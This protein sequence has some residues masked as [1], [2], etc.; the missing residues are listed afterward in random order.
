MSEII[1]LDARSHSFKHE[2]KHCTFE[3]DGEYLTCSTR[4]GALLNVSKTPLWRILPELLMDRSVSD[5]AR[6]HARIGRYTLVAGIV[7]YFSVIRDHV[8]L[9]APALF[10][11][12]GLCWLQFFRGIYPF[13]KTKIVSEYGDEIAVIPHH[14]DIA[15]RRKSFET[16]F[17]EAV[18]E[19]RSKHYDA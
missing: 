1:P 5:Y 18:R 4:R 3:F 6:Q 17:L 10:L 2:G 19:A 15:A 7:S 12:T 14:E 9:L 8:P 13:Q 11:W 16:A